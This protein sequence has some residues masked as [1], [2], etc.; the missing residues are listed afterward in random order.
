[1]ETAQIKVIKTALRKAE[2]DP[3]AYIKAVAVKMF[4]DKEAFN[5]R[6]E[7]YHKRYIDNE[8]FTSLNELYIVY[9]KIAKEENRERFAEE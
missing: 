9:Y 8:L 7:N 1:I 6:I 3:N 4:P 2:K 5:Q